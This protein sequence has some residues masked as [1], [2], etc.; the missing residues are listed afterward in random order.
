MLLAGLT[1]GIARRQHHRAPVVRARAPKMPPNSRRQPGM[2]MTNHLRDMIAGAW[3]GTSGHREN[4]L[5]TRENSG[6]R[7]VGPHESGAHADC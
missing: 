7:A 5:L 2:A 1:L 6:A 3:V 4:M